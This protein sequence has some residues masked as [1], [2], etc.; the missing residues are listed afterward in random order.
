MTNA[1]LVQAPQTS[2]IGKEME[3][4]M[5]KLCD[6]AFR[7]YDP[8]RDIFR[9]S[10]AKPYE[11]DY[12][13]AFK[14]FIV[15]YA[16]ERQKIVPIL[17][18]KLLDLADGQRSAGDLARWARD[19]IQTI[20]EIV[21]NE[22]SKYAETFLSHAPSSDGE[23]QRSSKAFTYRGPFQ[24]FLLDIVNK[25]C[26][27]MQPILDTMD[28]PTTIELVTWLRTHYDLSSLMDGEGDDDAATANT[29]PRDA[30]LKSRLSNLFKEAISKIVFSR[31]N[32]ILL[33]EI[34]KYSPKPE[35]LVARP[36]AI[37]PSRADELDGEVLDAEGPV[38]S[39]IDVR[40]AHL[41]GPG[42][43]NA[44]PPVKTAVRLLMIFNDLTHDSKAEEVSIS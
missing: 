39:G 32:E 8:Y 36:S 3:G 42:L 35:D 20:L 4:F 41:L 10:E 5:G 38:T 24:T 17:L 43:S 18:D 2:A 37:I 25:G 21:T 14:S 19:S 44:Y 30:E 9:L 29:V 31:M 15:E 33:R 16:T 1:F 11:G 34:E 23:E 22:D 6:I 12:L 7:L 40:A 27:A 26:I 13:D 28:I